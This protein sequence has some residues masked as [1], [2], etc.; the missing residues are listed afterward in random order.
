MSKQT[1]LNSKFS[2]H[3]GKHY[4]STDQPQGSYVTIEKQQINHHFPLH[5]HEHV[6]L[7]Y[8]TAGT[9]RL[10]VNGVEHKLCAGSFAMLFPFHFHE[11]IVDEPIEQYVITIDLSIMIWMDISSNDRNIAYEAIMEGP[12]VV[13]CEEQEQQEIAAILQSLQQEVSRES[14]MQTNMIVLLAM[15]LYVHF[16]RKAEQAYTVIEQQSHSQVWKI[17]QHIHLHF[18]EPL[19]AAGIARKFS[20]SA[21]AL[22][23]TLRLATGYNFTDNVHQ[24][25]I[26]TARALLHFEGLTIQYIAQ[27]VGY[28]TM[29]AFYR[30]FEKYIG[31][32]PGDYRSQKEVRTTT[33]PAPDNDNAY[34][35][36]SYISLH[37]E[38]PLSTK[39]VAEALG[40]N[41]TKLTKLISGYFGQSFAELLTWLR[42]A[43]A[44]AY[45][46][47]TNLPISDIAYRAGFDSVKTF[48][49]QF[50]AIIGDVPTKY[51][52][53]VTCRY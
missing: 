26:R 39:S 48:N 35:I 8:V 51:R 13:D 19:S 23:R 20:M 34:C 27:S 29:I 40:M 5:K 21:D 49:R 33:L 43:Y 7:L 15:Q 12:V 28:S 52:E 14:F 6:E 44:R 3:A 2:L 30:A 16:T 22:N 50:K 17:L 41:E 25:R 9:G 47:A 32:A 46:G 53:D 10:V 1:F 24:V 36:Y 38:E 11:I 45:L 37:I 4:F 31:V 18:H 42:I